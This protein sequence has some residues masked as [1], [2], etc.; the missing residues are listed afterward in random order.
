MVILLTLGSCPLCKQRFEL[1]TEPFMS[2][3]DTHAGAFWEASNALPVAFEVR[4]RSLR[5]FFFLLATLAVTIASSRP[6]STLCQSNLDT[7][8]ATT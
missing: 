8:F 3:Y 1:L 7:A 2:F 5:D 6:F 4:A